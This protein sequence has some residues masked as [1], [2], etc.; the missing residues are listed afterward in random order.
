MLRPSLFFARR[1]MNV[2]VILLP[3][4]LKPEHLRER[5]VVAFDVL[6]AT[7]SMTAALASGIS[8]IRVFGELEAAREAATAYPGPRLLCGERNARKPA[9]FD[10]GNSP[11]EFVADACSGRVAFMSTTNGTRAILAAKGAAEIL[12]GALV[13]ADAVAG[14]LRHHQREVT[15][16]CAGTEGSVSAEDVLGAGAVISQLRGGGDLRLLS[17]TA[18]MAEQLFQSARDGLEAAL[19]ES[20]GGQNV[21]CAGL[22]DDIPFA[23]RLNVF[24]VVGRVQGDPP[25]VRRWA[26][27]LA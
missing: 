6:R 12:V 15:L 23:A 7:T 17:D 24:D 3:R 13:N 25:V 9:E 27:A 19:M 22:A 1:F 18:W 21:R 4:D 20:R 26:D 14:A 5:V 10:L 11:G 16:L 2:D 8:E